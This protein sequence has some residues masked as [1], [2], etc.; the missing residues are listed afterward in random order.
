MDATD[1]QDAT[2]YVYTY[3]MN[4]LPHSSNWTG[5]FVPGERVRLRFINV[6]AMT[7][8]DVRIPGLKMSIVQADGQN[9]H[10]VEVDEFR[11][12]PAETYDVIVTPAEDRAYTIFSEVL[13][14]SGY[15]R[16]TLAP[17]L[18]MTAAVPERRPRPLRT[19]QSMGMSMEGMGMASMKLEVAENLKAG[20]DPLRDMAEGHDMPMTGMGESGKRKRATDAQGAHQG[21]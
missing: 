9:V 1:L 8:H 13:D 2:G 15:A 6:G 16:G 14:R 19:M 18:G 5:L 7:F 3:L 11:F 17:R 21:H 12:G 20:G 4:G 10:P